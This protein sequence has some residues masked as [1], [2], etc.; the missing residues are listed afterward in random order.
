MKKIFIFIEHLSTS[1][2]SAGVSFLNSLHS[3]LPA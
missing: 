1:G 2:P 3:P